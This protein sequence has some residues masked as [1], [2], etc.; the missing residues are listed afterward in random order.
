MVREKRER[1]QVTRTPRPT[2]RV[3]ERRYRR[4]GLQQSFVPF[5]YP[6]FERGEYG[7]GAVFLGTQALALATTTALFYASSWVLPNPDGTNTQE[8]D[9]LLPALRLGHYLAAGATVL[10]YGAG[11]G[12]ALLTFRPEVLD[13]VEV[14][15]MPI[16]EVPEVGRKP[17]MEQ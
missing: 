13:Y 9:Q 5:G 1:E 14:R 16:D 11:V 8:A 12:H 15:E 10:T 6:Q 17:Q 4:Q 7:W 2:I 3:V